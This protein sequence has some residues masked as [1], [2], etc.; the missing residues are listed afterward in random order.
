M[1]INVRRAFKVLAIAVA[2]SVAAGC[3]SVQ[4]EEKVDRAIAL[5]EQ[6]ASDASSAK[7]SASSAAATASE[8]KSMASNA[9]NAAQSAQ[10]AADQ[11]NAC[12]AANS[13]KLDRMF[14]ESMTK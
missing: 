8:A 14:R 6:A 2:V 1:S 13:D 5:A 9:M 11:A 7:S 3:S 12:C 10:R 4:L